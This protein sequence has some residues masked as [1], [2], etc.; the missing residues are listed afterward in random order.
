MYWTASSE[1][2]NTFPVSGNNSQPVQLA[3]P[4]LHLHQLSRMKNTPVLLAQQC[5]A[6][7]TRGRN[8]TLLWQVS[9]FN[10]CIFLFHTVYKIR[11]WQH[12][13]EMFGRFQRCCPLYCMAV[14][15]ECPLV[16]CRG[17]SQGHSS[18]VWLAT[19]PQATC[20]HELH[21]ESLYPTIESLFEVKLWHTLM[22]FMFLSLGIH[23]V[24]CGGFSVH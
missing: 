11:T 15:W 2:T 19:Y 16:S 5:A 18:C 8:C 23:N 1:Y 22:G 9:W 3:H 4:L 21:L 12:S 17:L 13:N 7:L 14:L 6:V 24:W 20:S 10:D